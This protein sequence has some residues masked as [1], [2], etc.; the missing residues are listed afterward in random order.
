MQS[1]TGL[2]L[3]ISQ[4]IAQTQALKNT[5]KPVFFKLIVPDQRN[6]FEDL[7]QNTENLQVFDYIEAQVEELIKCLQPMIVFM[8]P[9]ASLF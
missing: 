8:P 9:A 3:K 4:L 5:Y 1:K 6:A 7:L 2:A